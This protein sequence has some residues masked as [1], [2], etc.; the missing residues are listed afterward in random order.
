[1]A[2]FERSQMV[3]RGATYLGAGGKF[4][5]DRPDPAEVRRRYSLIAG[6]TLVA[7]APFRL[8]KDTYDLTEHADWDIGQARDPG[9]VGFACAI[10]DLAR[11]LIHPH[12]IDDEF[13][14]DYLTCT[15]LAA[16]R[17]LDLVRRPRLFVNAMTRP[18]LSELKRSA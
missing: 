12:S 3:A 17:I 18:T 9:L 1:M 4:P 15:G 8:P 7:Q 13:G 6:S 14:P 16:D 11:S 5:D 10:R 2:S